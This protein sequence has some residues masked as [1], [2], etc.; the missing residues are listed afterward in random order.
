MKNRKAIFLLVIILLIIQGCASPTE[1]KKDT[2]QNVYITAEIASGLPQKEM[3]YQTVSD[4]LN[5]FYNFDYKHDKQTCLQ[6]NKQLV[7]D[8]LYEFIQRDILLNYSEQN[9][10]ILT[11]LKIEGYEQTSPTSAKI[12]VDMYYKGTSTHGFSFEEIKADHLQ[13][14]VE[15]VNNNNKWLVNNL[16]IVNLSM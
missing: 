2:K 4:F 10:S 3:E 15:I 7:T 6:K 1:N 8:K 16:D 5:A 9:M 12:K 14:T 11:A 13:G